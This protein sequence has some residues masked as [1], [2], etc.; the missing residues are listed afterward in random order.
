MLATT[1]TR[2]IIDALTFV[3]CELKRTDCLSSLVNE[4]KKGGNG[5]TVKISTNFHKGLDCI[6]SKF[7]VTEVPNRDK[8]QQ[9]DRPVPSNGLQGFAFRCR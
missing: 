1:A 7:M 8:T 3:S 6:A 9:V 4:H 2:Q 5:E